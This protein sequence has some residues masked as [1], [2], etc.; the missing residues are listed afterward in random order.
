MYQ[1]QRAST[2][3]TGF[4]VRPRI[5]GD[6]LGLVG[7]A[8]S[9]VVWGIGGLALAAI[10]RYS[11]RKYNKKVAVAVT[12]SAVAVPAALFVGNRWYGRRRGAATQSCIDQY[13]TQFPD[14]CHRASMTGAWILHPQYEQECF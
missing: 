2:L 13:C 7:V 12:G 8:A 9:I 1:P 10:Y 11:K 6:E 14:H 5:M 4:D 3:G